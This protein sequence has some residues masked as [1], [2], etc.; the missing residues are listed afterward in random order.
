LFQDELPEFLSEL[1]THLQGIQVAGAERAQAVARLQDLVDT[2][3]VSRLQCFISKQVLQLVDAETATTSNTS[4][5]P[6]RD[7]IVKWI[8]DKLKPLRNEQDKAVATALLLTAYFSKRLY[9]PSL[10]KSLVDAVGGDDKHARLVVIWF[11]LRLSL[12][13]AK[14]LDMESL[15]V[16]CRRRGSI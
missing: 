1:P 8:E 10:W 5:A 2:L 6:V 12:K 16:S 13:Q 14:G 15:R 4:T 3:Y 9:R 11:S 7:T